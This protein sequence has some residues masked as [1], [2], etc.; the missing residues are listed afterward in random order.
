MGKI[1][2]RKR[3]FTGIVWQCMRVPAGG[4]FDLSTVMAAASETMEREP[5]THAKHWF[6]ALLRYKYVERVKR[7][8]RYRLAANTGPR[9]PILFWIDGKPCLRDKNLEK[10]AG[11]ARITPQNK[12]IRL[13]MA[14]IQ[15]RKKTN[16]SKKKIKS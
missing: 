10:D 16:G 14:R 7:D 15:R 8:G 1:K 2:K 5:S 4:Y 13:V 11:G 9:S 12:S 6:A 3:T